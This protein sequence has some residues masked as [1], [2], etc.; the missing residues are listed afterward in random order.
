MVIV[1]SFE[2][3]N[4]SE[5]LC[6]TGLKRGEFDELLAAFTS[7]YERQHRREQTQTGTA[8]KRGAGGGCKGRLSNDRDKLLFM[9]VFLKTNPLQTVHGLNF[10]LSQSQTNFWIHHLLPIVR[11]ALHELG[12]SPEREAH[13]VKESPL[14]HEGGAALLLDG[15]E[16][17]RGRPQHNSQQKAH[18]SGKK[19]AHTDKNLVLTNENSGKVAYLS[20][21]VA[22]KTHDKKMADE[23]NIVYPPGAVL[24]KDTGFQGY[25]P[26]GVFTLQPQKRDEDDR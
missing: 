12:H 22:G 5:L 10:G 13:L 25:E 24:A 6:A 18:Y 17:R 2:H 7:V 26:A 19:K 9:L 4:E 3:L 8:R 14:I 15:T 20:P 11:Q 16:R 23:A 21:T 1:K